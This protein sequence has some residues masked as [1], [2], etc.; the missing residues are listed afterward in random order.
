ME[1]FSLKKFLK[2]AVDL[3]IWGFAMIFLCVP[4]SSRPD[5]C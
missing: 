5:Y 3:K 2:P 1:A 4:F